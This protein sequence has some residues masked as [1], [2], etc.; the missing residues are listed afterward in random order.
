M[1]DSLLRYL[2][3]FTH[4]CVRIIETSIEGIST[5][6]MS[7]HEQ[8]LVVAG[9]K[10]SVDKERLISLSPFFESLYSGPFKEAK[11]GS[12]DI[13]LKVPCPDTFGDVLA[14]AESLRNDI[15]FDDHLVKTESVN[16]SKM[17]RASALILNCIFLQILDVTAPT[18]GSDR[19]LSLFLGEGC[20][21]EEFE[22]SK[23][24][25]REY[26][27]PSFLDDWFSLETQKD[28]IEL[29]ELVLRWSGPS[30]DAS[31]SEC[32]PLRKLANDSKVWVGGNRTSKNYQRILCLKR[33]YRKTFS[34][35][36]DSS[37]LVEY[38][39]GLVES[40][41]VNEARKISSKLHKVLWYECKDC[42][43][44]SNL[45]SPCR[46]IYHPG[47]YSVAKLDGSGGWSCCGSAKKRVP[48][49]ADRDSHVLISNE[50][51]VMTF[52]SVQF[53][54][55]RAPEMLEYLTKQ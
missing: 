20:G 44:I 36:V 7:K 37:H 12:K 39:E 28:G 43:L 3:G 6:T 52:Q 5:L 23:W 34:I 13:V 2:T 29:L 32:E 40:M 9:R 22:G 21:R 31:S 27:E 30:L 47:S 16:L 17:D 55:E 48:G 45:E 18:K 10:Y 24:F 14:Y 25:S 33:R 19:I 51:V 15:D 38:M 26:F 46:G 54:A 41:R 8:V 42:G 11:K 49:C 1:T 50:S 4:V 35:L 53:P